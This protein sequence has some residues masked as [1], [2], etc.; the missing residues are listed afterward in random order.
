MKAEQWGRERKETERYI[1]KNQLV[2]EG[3][4]KRKKIQKG[5]GRRK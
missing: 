3:D 4:G 1:K 2:G 5:G